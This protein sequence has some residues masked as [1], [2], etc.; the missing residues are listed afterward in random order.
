VRFPC[1]TCKLKA[2]PKS[3]LNAH[4]III[5]YGKRFPCDQCD[6]QARSRDK[7]TGDLSCDNIYQCKI[8]MNIFILLLYF[9]KEEK[10]EQIKTQGP[11]K[12]GI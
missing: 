11:C 5:H 1:K 12:G 9:Q 8:I 6:F 10:E 3:D 4:V 7:V 2:T